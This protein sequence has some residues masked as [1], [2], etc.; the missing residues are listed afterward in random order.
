MASINSFYLSG[1]IMDNQIHEHTVRPFTETKIKC[2][3]ELMPHEFTVFSS[4]TH[5]LHPGERVFFEGI[6]KTKNDK[7]VLVAQT[8]NSMGGIHVAKSSAEIQTEPDQAVAQESQEMV[9]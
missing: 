4:G 6:L 9:G 1:F 8:I 2:T 3:V 7:T 5:V